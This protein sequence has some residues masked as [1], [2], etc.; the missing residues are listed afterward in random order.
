M[1]SVKGPFLLGLLSINRHLDC[2]CTTAGSSPRRASNFFVIDKEVTKKA[3]PQ[4]RG[5]SADP[6]RCAVEKAAAELALRA[7][8]VLADGYAATFSPC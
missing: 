2:C 1:H 7:Q 3:T 8:T 5:P 6:L 4:R